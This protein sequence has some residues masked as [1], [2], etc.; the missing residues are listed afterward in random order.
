MKPTKNDIYK[1]IKIAGMVSFIPFVLISGPL[2]GFLA[3]DFLAAKLNL[4]YLKIICIGIG[5]IAAIFETFKIVRLVLK[6]DK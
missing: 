6:L 3:G 4:P 2:V 1:F 5:I